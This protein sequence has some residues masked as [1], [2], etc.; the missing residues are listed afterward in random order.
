MSNRFLLFIS[1][2]FL[3]VVAQAQEAILELESDDVLPISSTRYDDAVVPP[4]NN[5]SSTNKNDMWEKFERGDLDEKAFVRLQE[6]YQELANNSKDP[7]VKR[8]LASE[9]KEKVFVEAKKAK[10]EIAAKKTEAKKIAKDKKKKE[11]MAEN[12]EMEG[13]LSGKKSAN[14]EPASLP[15]K[16]S[17]KKK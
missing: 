4:K 8:K 17:K 16:K 13:K 5:F 11:M 1:V 12:L 7:V 14:R 9:R 10:L 15:A 3:S 6:E 2:F